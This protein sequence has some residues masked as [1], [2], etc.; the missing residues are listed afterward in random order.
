ML[1]LSI[2][3]CN[4]TPHWKKKKVFLTDKIRKQIWPNYYL[5]LTKAGKSLLYRENVASFE[6]SL[7]IPK[8]YLQN[9]QRAVNNKAGIWR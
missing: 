1:G 8:S 7:L 3:M 2:I 6:A 9:K 5:C 4:F